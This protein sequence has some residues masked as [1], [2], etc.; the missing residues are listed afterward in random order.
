LRTPGL[1][2][3]GECEMFVCNSCN[4]KILAATK[5]CQNLGKLKEYDKAK[6]KNTEKQKRQNKKWS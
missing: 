1:E 2:L 6:G 4:R 3:I 5:L